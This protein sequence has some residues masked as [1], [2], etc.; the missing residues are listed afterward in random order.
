MAE[1]GKL[2]L[3][4]RFLIDRIIETDGAVALQGRREHIPL[5]PATARGEVK[6]LNT[7]GLQNAHSEFEFTFHRHVASSAEKLCGAA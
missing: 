5:R 2:E 7:F 6:P 3:E 4:V 1:G